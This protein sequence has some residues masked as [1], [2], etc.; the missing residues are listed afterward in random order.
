MGRNAIA[1]W[2]W[3]DQIFRRDV[4]NSNSRF[5]AILNGFPEGLLFFS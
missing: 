2:F 4:I 5:L 3:R 1:L